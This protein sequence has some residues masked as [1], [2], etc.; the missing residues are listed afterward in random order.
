MLPCATWAAPAQ[1]EPVALTA[2]DAPPILVVGN[3]GDPATPL[4]NAEAVA[5]SLDSGV[6]VVADMDG[7]TAYGANRCVTEIVDDYFT[8]L[9]LPEQDTRC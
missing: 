5:D 7:H 9:A 1:D 3:T 6:L 8:E 2:S 4:L